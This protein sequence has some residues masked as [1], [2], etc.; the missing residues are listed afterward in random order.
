MRQPNFTWF[1]PTLGLR[2]PKIVQTKP[3]RFLFIY[4]KYSNKDYNT[5][6]SNTASFQD[7]TLKV[8]IT[9]IALLWGLSLMNNI[10]TTSPSI[11]VFMS[12]GSKEGLHSPSRSSLEQLYNFSLFMLS[13]VTL[14]LLIIRVISHSP[15]SNWWRDSI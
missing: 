9:K 14:H 3:S 7:I 13:L 4:T 15:Y 8:D 1:T 11:P 6:S 2:P 10:N 12:V 5:S